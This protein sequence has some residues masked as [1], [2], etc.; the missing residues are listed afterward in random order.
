MGHRVKIYERVDA[1]DAKHPDG[2]R[3]DRQLL[4]P[5]A[6]DQNAADGHRLRRLDRYRAVGTVVIGMLFLGEPRD[7]LRIGFF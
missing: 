2:S 5:V 6:R 3:H 1:A 7:L 4:F